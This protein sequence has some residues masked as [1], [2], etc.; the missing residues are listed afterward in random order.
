MSE[1]I[2]ILSK[3]LNDKPS[4][5]C[6]DAV[7]MIDVKSGRGLSNPHYEKGAEVIVAGFPA[8]PAW[9][10]PS[11]LKLF[12]PARFGYDIPYVPIE[13]LHGK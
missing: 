3:I 5:L 11:G 8:V 9:R 1:V 10:T 4:V 12:G 13:E 7:T 6:P 2:F